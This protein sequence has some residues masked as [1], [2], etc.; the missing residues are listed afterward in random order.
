MTTKDFSELKF[1]YF[2]FERSFNFVHSNEINRRYNKKCRRE[3]GII[4][5]SGSS[6]IKKYCTDRINHFRTT[7]RSWYEKYLKSNPYR[8]FFCH[9]RLHSYQMIRVLQTRT[10]KSAPYP[11]PSIV[12]L[13][14]YNTN[15]GKQDIIFISYRCI[16]SQLAQFNTYTWKTCQVNL[17]NYWKSYIPIHIVH[18][19]LLWKSMA[20]RSRL[21][22]FYVIL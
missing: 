8:H 2:L 1:F 16:I 11:L 7:I 17:R 12:F 5:N 3:I 18:W 6:N 19:L 14:L 21:A 4:E 15:V 13:D 10:E 22:K 20:N 9:E